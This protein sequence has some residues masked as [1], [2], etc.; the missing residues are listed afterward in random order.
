MMEVMNST[1]IYMMYYKNFCK[2]HN[3]PPP[4]TIIK[5]EEK[6]KHLSFVIYHL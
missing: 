4:S 6:I 5:K 1:M 3:V 2:Y